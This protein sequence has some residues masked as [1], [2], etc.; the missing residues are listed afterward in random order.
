MY[1]TRGRPVNIINLLAFF[2]TGA[3]SMT[4]NK[5]TKEKQKNLYNKPAE[6]S[7]E[8]YTCKLK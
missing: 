2:E 4:K 3:K 8:K 1:F 6:P 5:K 7:A